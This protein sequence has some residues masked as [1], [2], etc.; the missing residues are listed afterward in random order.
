MYIYT[1]L[2][3]DGTTEV[4]DTCKTKWDYKKLSGHIGGFIEIIPSDYYPKGLTGTVYGHE[5]GRFNE[6]NHRNPHLL[7]ITDTFGDVWDTVG[8]L[9]L[10][11]TE[12]QNATWLAT[13]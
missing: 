9:L 12:K 8:D 1:A 7:A 11:Q 3:Q 6:L 10:E 5:E 2:K 4:L 13:L